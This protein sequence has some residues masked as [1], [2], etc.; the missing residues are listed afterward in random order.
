VRISTALFLA[1]ALV[2]LLAIPAPN[3][4]LFVIVALCLFVLAAWVRE[5]REGEV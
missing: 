5:E 4:F 1:A 3:G 2:A